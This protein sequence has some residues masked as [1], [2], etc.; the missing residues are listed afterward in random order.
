MA[1]LIETILGISGTTGSSAELP[2][3]IDSHH[4]IKG[5]MERRDAAATEELLKVH[6]LD[7]GPPR[8]D[9]RRAP[10]EA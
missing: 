8:G 10:A 9:P 2:G 7:R 1:P 6:L 5:A 4:K 3:A